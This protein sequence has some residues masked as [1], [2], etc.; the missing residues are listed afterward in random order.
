MI[1][2]NLSLS[3]STLDSWVLDTVSRSHLCKLLQRLQGIKKLNEGDFMLYD[4]SGESTKAEV[5][6]THLLKL[7]S[8][9]VLEL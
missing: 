7:P 1:Q 4:A 6:G 3:T 8:K 5:V 9:K 2:T